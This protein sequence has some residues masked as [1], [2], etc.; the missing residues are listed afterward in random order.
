MRALWVALIMASVALAGCSEEAKKNVDCIEGCG[1][2]VDPGDVDKDKGVIRGVVVDETISPIADATITIDGTEHET[3]SDETGGF[4]FVNLE[5]RTYFMTVKKVGYSTVQQGHDVIAGVVDP[6][7]IKV[8][9]A[10]QVGTEPFNI[11]KQFQGYIGCAI[12]LANVPVDNVCRHAD[13]DP[14]QNVVLDFGTTQIPRVLHTEIVWEY[15]QEI[16]KS[17][18]TMQFVR[19]AEGNEQRI[20]NA[21]G[22][23]PLICRVT[24]QNVC[25][26]GD[27]TGGGG[28]GLN[29][30]GFPGHF[31]ARVYAACYPECAIGAVGAGL[32]LQQDYQLFSIAFFNYAPPEGWTLSADGMYEP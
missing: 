31:R 17:L 23:S 1:P 8:M 14:D 9:L 4:V 11:A 15:S 29:E 7:I 30:T 5:P 13:L 12:K 26:N 20:G 3:T 22:P 19:E 24:Q 32:I 10:R 25:D 16:G 21:W 2:V 28:D 6:P 18:G 27:G